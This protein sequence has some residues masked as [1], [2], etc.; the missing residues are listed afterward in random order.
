MFAMRSYAKLLN[1][2]ADKSSAARNTWLDSRAEVVAFSEDGG[3]CLQSDC[4]TQLRDTG[5]SLFESSCQFYSSGG[6]SQSLSFSLVSLP[7]IGQA[8]RLF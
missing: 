2:P 7:L 1:N 6:K 4:E 3:H 8:S 5:I